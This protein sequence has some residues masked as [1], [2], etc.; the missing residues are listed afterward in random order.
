MVNILKSLMFEVGAG[1]FA[2]DP[3]GTIEQNFSVLLICKRFIHDLQ[4]LTECVS[5]RT[6]CIF[7]M[8]DL[9][10]IVVTHIDHQGIFFARKIMKLGR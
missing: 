3:A 5:I 7:E 9:T 8:S 6:V 10:L 4:G 1:F 2:T